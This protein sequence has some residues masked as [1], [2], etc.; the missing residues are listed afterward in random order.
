MGFFKHATALVETETI[1]EETRI[2]AFAHVMK[3]VVIGSGCN[4][5]DHSFVESGVTIGN[6]VTIKNGVSIW[7]GVTIEDLV[8]IGPNAVFTNDLR[9][10]SKVYHSL[11]VKTVIS[12]GA[13]I[14]ANATIVAG[15][16]LGEYCMIGAGAVVSKSV[17]PFELV[18]GLPAR[19]KG[20]VAKNGETL[21]FVDGR[22]EVDGEIYQLKDNHVSIIS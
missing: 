19:H 8:F 7:S 12:R 10:R 6:D 4:V 22:A 11:P 1:G 2:W 14:G 3:D 21:H 9:P 20:F 5:G 16:T 15:V 17:R 18:T 13:S